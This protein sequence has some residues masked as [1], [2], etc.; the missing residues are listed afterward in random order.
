MKARPL[1]V[2]LA[3]AGIALDAAILAATTW[4]GTVRSVSGD[5]ATVAMNGDVMP[6]AGAPAEI[7]FKMA[8]LDDEVLV[9]TG[10]V[11]RI[12]HGDL[13]VK[14]ENATGTVECGQLVRFSFSSSSTP[15]ASLPAA[16]P[17]PRQ[18]EAPAVTATETGPT[19][20]PTEAARYFAEGLTK[21]DANDLRGALAAFTKAIQLDPTYAKAYVNRANIYDSLKQPERGLTEANEAIRLNPQLSNAYLIR[22]NCYEDMH[23]HKRAIEDYDEAIRLDP[24][25]ADA[26]SNR[27]VVYKKLGQN[28]SAIE[29]YTQALE[30]DPQYVPALTNRA[31][32][33]QAMGKTELAKRDF[34]RVQELKKKQ[35]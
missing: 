1:I 26:Y 27:G 31:N 19:P 6:P 18:T 15:A 11:L 34:A 23:Q 2:L 16:T 5:I 35:H 25:N 12:D 10:S 4:T 13:L 32:L 24:K 33:Y 17:T 14:I 9:A 28:K 21:F 20:T 3:C 30:A 29:S 7:F 22:G 8:G